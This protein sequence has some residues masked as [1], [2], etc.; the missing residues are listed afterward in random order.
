MKSTGSEFRWLAER[1]DEIQDALRGAGLDGW[2]LYDLHARNAVAGRL[3]GVGDL[4]RRYFA[5]IPAEGEPTVVMHGIETAAWDAWPWRKE[6]Y[7][8]WRALDDRLGALL[9]GKKVAVE[10]SPRDAV[11]AVD[12]IPAGVAELLRTAGAELVSSADLVTR[13]YA[14]WDEDGYAS[15]RRAAAVLAQVAR[16]AFRRAADGVRAGSPVAEG[17]LHGWIL[18]QLA[19]RGV[20]TGPDAIVANG[21]HAAD[22][23]YANDGPGAPLRQG[24]VVLIDLWSREPDGVYADQTWMGFLGDAVPEDVQRYWTAIR[25]AR[26]AAVGFLHEAWS[27]G[28]TVQGYEVDDACRGVVVE[29]GLGDHFI[30]RTG[31]S[32]DQDVH[33]MGPN[34][35]NLE[36]HETRLLIEGVGFS[37]EPGIYVP[38]QVGLRTEIDVYMGADG[39]EV[40]TPDPQPEIFT[41]LP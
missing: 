37:I 7:V 32:I 26:D 38:G 10:L 16:E 8:G 36:T 27:A 5:L 29:R 4:T 12:L 20:G 24:D 22:P 25:D 33:G 9:Q 28:R 11:P 31:H 19:A 2:L 23:H 18:G 40:T 41:L 17:E 35:D 3:L 34:M 30:H 6:S 21:P 39:P 13:F 14:R 15:H 1:L